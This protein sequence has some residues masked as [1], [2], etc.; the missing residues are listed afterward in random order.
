MKNNNTPK[1]IGNI[2]KSIGSDKL[3]LLLVAGVLL[4]LS[5]G[6]GTQKEKEQTQSEAAGSAVMERSY[7]SE[8]E[9][10]LKNLLES[11]YGA[12]NVSVMIT[13]EES[14]NKVL[15]TVQEECIFDGDT[16]YVV[17]NEAPKI[18]GVVV[19][20]EKS[21]SGVALEITQACEVLLGIS[22]NR[23]RV[24]NKK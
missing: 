9:T 3:I 24:I 11:A 4:L 15:A 2:I 6:D 18:R 14:E 10:R 12:G 22:S 20:L 13:M 17:K 19:V 1:T 16:P 7:E 5:M 8:L 23:V 21:S